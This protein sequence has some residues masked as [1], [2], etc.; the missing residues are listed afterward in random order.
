MNYQD[1]VVLIREL[2]AGSEVAFDYLFRMSYT[3]LCHFAYSFVADYMVAE[4]IVQ[5][6]FVR[7]WMK[8]EAIDENQALDSYLYVSVRNACYTYLKNKKDK[9]QLKEVS[10]V[11]AD[12]TPVPETE[13]EKLLILRRL[14]EELPLQ[15][16]V[17]FKLVVWEEMKYQEVAAYLNI[18]VNTVKTQMKIAYKLLREKIKPFRALFLAFY[19]ARHILA[20]IE[21]KSKC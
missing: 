15:C 3:E 17:I 8:K 4:D 20:L 21:K 2:R 1:Q 5:G 18:S 10:S 11:L 14:I 19:T 12:E 6:I 7:I 9:T 13:P 16:K